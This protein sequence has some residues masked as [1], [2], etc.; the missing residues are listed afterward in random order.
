MIW[1]HFLP[2]GLTILFAAPYTLGDA[3]DE[4]AGRGQILVLNTTNIGSATPNDRIG[5][6]NKHGML[7][8]SD[9]AIFT[10]S[11]GIPHLSTSEGGCSFQNPRM[12]TNE[13]SIYGRNT[14]A[15]SC[16]DHAKPDGTPVSETYY[17]LNGLDYPLICH[18]NLACYYDIVAN[19]SP[20]NANPAPVWGYY[21]G[22]QQ[23]TAPPG[24]WQ[25]AWLWVQV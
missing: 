23:M 17:S 20:S 4:F 6:L 9:C 7:T 19:P 11:D 12:P 8:L 5:C 2:A 3:S 25:V 15:W 24:H 14:R 21:W 13:D 22:S 1:K 10:H 16:S 18:G